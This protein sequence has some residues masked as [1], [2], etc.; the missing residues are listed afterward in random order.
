MTEIIYPD[1]E[2]YTSFSSEADNRKHCPFNRLRECYCYWK[3]RLVAGNWKLIPPIYDDLVKGLEEYWAGSVFEPSC[4]DEET[5]IYDHPIWGWGI[6][7]NFCP[8]VT[9]KAIGIFSDHVIQYGDKID[10]KIA[11]RRLRAEGTHGDTDWRWFYW[12]VN[13]CHYS[14]C[15]LYTLNKDRAPR[16]VEPPLQRPSATKSTSVE[17]FPTPKGSSWEDVRIRFTD[18]QRVHVQVKDESGTYNFTQMGMNNRKSGEPTVQWD[19]MEEFANNDGE[20][21]CRDLTIRPKYQ[22]RKEKLAK[23]LQVF[24]E[25]EDDPIE[26]LGPGKG[27][28]ARFMISF[29]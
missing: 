26:S 8:E 20:F 23:D 9:Y 22:K 2:W 5:N 21:S 16:H 19:L 4:G 10:R 29:K 3:S 14:D 15:R 7:K 28:R 13:P 1:I 27:W 24:F 25:I 17:K 11:H 18:G 12:H 6:I